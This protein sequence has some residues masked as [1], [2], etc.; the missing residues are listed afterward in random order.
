MQADTSTSGDPVRLRCASREATIA[1]ART[2]GLLLGGREVIALSGPLGAGKTTFVK[3]LAEGL[4]IDPRQVTSP[5]FLL[6]HELAGRLR[7]AH[8]DAYR[9]SGG[10]E[11]REAG[12]EDLVGGEG[13]AAIE[14]AERVAD[15]LPAD[16][17]RVDLEPDGEEGRVLVFTA[18]GPA[19]SALLRRLRAALPTESEW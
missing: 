1:A 10:E 8:M 15:L 19:S 2:L 9:V 12:A 13:V 4:G 5:T 3:G 16:H 7:L 11:L 6:I 14:W 17:L 18:G